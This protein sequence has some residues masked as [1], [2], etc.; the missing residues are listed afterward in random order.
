M[1]HNKTTLPQKICP[2]CQRPPNWLSKWQTLIHS[3]SPI[4]DRYHVMAAAK[5]SAILKRN[6]P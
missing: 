2:V 4:L 3:Q 1:I 6:H 5:V